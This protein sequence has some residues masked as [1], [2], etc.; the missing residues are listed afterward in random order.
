[1]HPIITI[2]SAG[3]VFYTAKDVIPFIAKSMNNTANSIASRVRERVRK[4]RICRNCRLANK[5]NYTKL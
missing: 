4:R 1:M 5:V 3:C 2:M